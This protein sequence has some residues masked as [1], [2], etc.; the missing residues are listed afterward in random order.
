MT[1]GARRMQWTRSTFEDQLI[2]KVFPTITPSFTSIL[3]KI[4]NYSL[5][6]TYTTPIQGKTV[7][8][9]CSNSPTHFLKFFKHKNI[10]Q[11]HKNIQKYFIVHL[12]TCK[13]FMT[14]SKILAITPAVYFMHDPLIHKLS[15][16]MELTLSR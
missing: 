9:K 6:S 16:S 3:S 10:L 15:P 2:K 5:I 13:Y 11:L 4:K 14:Y 8:K 7:S 12:Y 1:Y